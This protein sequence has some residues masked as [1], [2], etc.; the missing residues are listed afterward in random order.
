YNNGTNFVGAATSAPFSFTWVN[1]ASGTNRIVAVASDNLGAQGSSAVLVFFVN[2][3]PKVTIA[4]PAEGESF[5]PGSNIVIHAVAS[6]ADGTVARV[7]F[8]E[9]ATSL[10]VV[11]NAPFNL[12]WGDSEL[13]AYSLRVVATDNRGMTTTSVPVTVN[14]R[15]PNDTF[16]DMFAERGTIPGFANMIQGSNTVATRELNEPRAYNSSTRTVWL[17]WVAPSSGT[18]FIETTGSTF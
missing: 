17:R 12:V 1:A 8:F 11:T 13:G 16:A 6:D 7:E 14:I 3:P 15:P 18:C 10:G 5:A 2:I 9:G 4:T